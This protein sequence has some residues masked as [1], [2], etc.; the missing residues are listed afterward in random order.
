MVIAYSDSYTGR[1]KYSFAPGGTGIHSFKHV[2]FLV[3]LGLY[4]STLKLSQDE[5]WEVVGEQQ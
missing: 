5:A 4:Y 3:V 1:I 2:A